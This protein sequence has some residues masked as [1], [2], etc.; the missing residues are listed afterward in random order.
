ME[1]TAN[2]ICNYPLNCKGKHERKKKGNKRKSHFNHC[3]T[4]YHTLSEQRNLKRSKA[5]FRF[6]DRNR[7]RDPPTDTTEVLTCCAKRWRR[8]R[9]HM[10]GCQCQPL[11]KA[12]TISWHS[13]KKGRKILANRPGPP[14]W[15]LSLGNGSSW[16]ECVRVSSC[17]TVFIA[18][19]HV[20]LMKH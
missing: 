11:G 17:N 6:N 13:I 8:N 12:S 15:K 10:S 7:K 1:E 4:F 19:E 9:F 3:L 18:N 14:D 2:A 16:A 20:Y 5:G